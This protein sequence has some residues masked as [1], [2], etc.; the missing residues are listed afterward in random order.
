MRWLH[1]VECQCAA[2]A[3]A[4]QRERAASSISS[5]PGS[6]IRKPTL[7]PP[8]PARQSRGATPRD[9]SRPSRSCRRARRAA[10]RRR[11]RR[12]RS[13]PRR[14]RPGRR[15]RKG[16][17]SRCRLPRWVR[18]PCAAPQFAELGDAVGAAHESRHRSWPDSRASRP[19]PDR[20]TPPC[21]TRPRR[22]K[23]RGRP[24]CAGRPP[25]RR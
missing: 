12:S 13:T 23:V 20:S 17:A 19:R 18:S 15:C 3:A 16:S 4:R 14:C 11:R 2:R 25:S 1:G 5:R 8:I 22:R 9:R 21:T 7:S 24:G 10:R 6:G